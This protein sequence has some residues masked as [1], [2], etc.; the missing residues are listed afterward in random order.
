MR[1]RCFT[2]AVDVSLPEFLGKSFR[3]KDWDTPLLQRNARQVI[4]SKKIM[5]PLVFVIM[6]I[7]KII[8][9]TRRR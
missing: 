5:I 2:A 7:V 3:G 4:F 6:I 1:L 9:T 8:I